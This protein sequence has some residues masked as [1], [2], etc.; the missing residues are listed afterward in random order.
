MTKLHFGRIVGVDEAVVVDVV[1][2]PLVK[3][4]VTAEL[5]VVVVKFPYGTLLVVVVVPVHGYE[6]DVVEDLV[7]SP[8]AAVDHDS[9]ALAALVGA[10]VPQ[11]PS[12]VFSHGHQVLV[13]VTVTI[14]YSASGS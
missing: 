1:V 5:V 6:V 2:V 7:L 11:L 10:H 12:P 4:V 13:F 3:G 14:T 8:P 9:H